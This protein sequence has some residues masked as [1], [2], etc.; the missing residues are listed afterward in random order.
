MNKTLTIALAFAAGLLG[1]LLARYVALPSVHA[2]AQAPSALEIR[3]QAFTLT[4]AQGH[5]NGTFTL[6]SDQATLFGLPL[7]P[8]IVLLDPVGRKIWT[9]GGAPKSVFKSLAQNPK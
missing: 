5:A 8:R 4:D 6:R 7:P 3:A 2:Q 9:A 1:G